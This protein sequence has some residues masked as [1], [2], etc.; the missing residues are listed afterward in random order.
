MLIP[1]AF[2]IIVTL[3]PSK[4]AIGLAGF[5]L[6]ATFAPAIGPTIVVHRELWLAL[7]L[8]RQSRPRY[9][10]AGRP[11]YTAEGADAAGSAAERRLAR[12]CAHG[13]RLAA[14]QTVL[15]EGTLMIGSARRSVHA[16]QILSDVAGLSGCAGVKFR[17]REALCVERRGRGMRRGIIWAGAYAVRMRESVSG[18]R[19]GAL[20]STRGRWR[21]C[22]RS[23]CRQ[24][25][26]GAGRRRGQ[27]W[28]PFSGSSTGSWKKISASPAKQRHTAKRIFE[29]LRDEHG[30]GGGITIVRGYVHE[31]RQRLREMFVPLRHDPGHAQ[32]D[33]GEAL[34][35]IAG[36]E[37]K[38]HFFAMDLPHSDACL[39]QAY[40]AESTR[41]LL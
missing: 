13:G 32:V 12:H 3:P 17:R 4:R 41:G 21:R 35:V 7:C 33:F 40:P 25:I 34:A 22:W 24:V 15:D 11:A 20:G 26:G 6:S 27:S 39:V 19:R 14:L 36:E 23:R 29:R 18:K 30:Y 10:H 5:A 38:I 31:H 37:C 8:L 1:L 9:R 2:T 28:I 16:E